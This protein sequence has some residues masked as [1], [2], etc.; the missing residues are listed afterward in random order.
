[1]LDGMSI[2]RHAKMD[3]DMSAGNLNASAIGI[4]QSEHIAP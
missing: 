3:G 2:G 1:M 4:S